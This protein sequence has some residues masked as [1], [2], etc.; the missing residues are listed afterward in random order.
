MSYIEATFIPRREYDATEEERIQSIELVVD[1]LYIAMFSLVPNE[2]KKEAA[3]LPAKIKEIR[4]TEAGIYIASVGLMN[5]DLREVV[6]CSA[7]LLDGYWRD[8]RE[9]RI[10]FDNILANTC[11][12]KKHGDTMDDELQAISTGVSLEDRELQLV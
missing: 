5:M 4:K 6:T 10:S 1:E 7:K 3:K 9:E 12:F 8:I 11:Y 2:S